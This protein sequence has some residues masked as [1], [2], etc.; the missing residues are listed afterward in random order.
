MYSDEFK[1]NALELADAS[2]KSD[3]QIER[4]LGMSA[5][6]LSQWRKRYQVSEESNRLELKRLKREN[7]VLTQER[8]IL[9]HIC[10]MTNLSLR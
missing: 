7:E 4:D 5:G 3:A 2:D 10:E 1:R 6:L 9:K 8:D